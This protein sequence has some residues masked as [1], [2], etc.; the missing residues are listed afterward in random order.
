MFC[1]VLFPGEVVLPSLSVL[2]PTVSSTKTEALVNS[3]SAAYMSGA[4]A[5]DV[6]NVFQTWAPG[7][8]EVSGWVVDP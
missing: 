4:F 6:F 1:L 2:A 5:R 7:L 3:L 8:G